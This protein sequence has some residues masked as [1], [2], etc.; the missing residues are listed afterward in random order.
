MQNCMYNFA[1]S[2]VRFCD[3]IY[4]NKKQSIMPHALQR[5][6]TL[7]LQRQLTLALQRQLTLALQRQLKLALQR[8]IVGEALDD[9]AKAHRD[10]Q[11]QFGYIDSD[12]RRNHRRP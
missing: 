9:P 4:L 1:K 12:P 6:L 10:P 8:H 3:A 5:Q 2:S 11:T 7:A